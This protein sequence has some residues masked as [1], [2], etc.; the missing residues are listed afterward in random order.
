MKPNVNFTGVHDM[1]EL[2]DWA[3]R[4]S[5]WATTGAAFVLGFVFRGLVG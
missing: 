1:N 5:G 4:Y 3:K 2:L